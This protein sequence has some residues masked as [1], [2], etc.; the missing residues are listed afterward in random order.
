MRKKLLYYFDN[1]R[2]IV[3]KISI[4][5]ISDID[6]NS[7]IP[8]AMS[9][10]DPMDSYNILKNIPNTNIHN[11]IYIPKSNTSIAYSFISENNPHFGNVTERINNRNILDKK[12]LKK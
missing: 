5:E 6:I 8:F 9:D 1:Y 4:N 3:T 2:Y 12:H 7:S 11:D 10:I